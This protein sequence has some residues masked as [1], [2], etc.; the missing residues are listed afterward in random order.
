MM[1][2]PYFRD[3]NTFR[4]NSEVA[5]TIDG[6]GECLGELVLVI[7]FNHVELKSSCL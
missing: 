2:L 1:I 7:D 6:L 5:L 3:E 4:D